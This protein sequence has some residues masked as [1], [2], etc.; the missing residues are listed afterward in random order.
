MEIIIQMKFWRLFKDI[1]TFNFS[2]NSRNYQFY[3]SYREVYPKGIKADSAF[4]HR[5]LNNK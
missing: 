5:E 4:I 3:T 1:R 2:L